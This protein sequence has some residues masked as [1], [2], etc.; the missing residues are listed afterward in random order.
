[1]SASPPPYYRH[2]YCCF[3]S[4]PGGNLS[5]IL[6][7]TGTCRISLGRVFLQEIPKHWSH[8]SCNKNIWVWFFV[9]LGIFGKLWVF[10]W[11]TRKKQVPLFPKKSL[12]LVP[13]YGKI[14]PEHGYGSQA[15][16]GTPGAAHPDPNLRPSPPPPPAWTIH[17][18][19]FI[20]ILQTFHVWR[21]DIAQDP[22][23]V[24]VLSGCAEK[25]CR[26][27]WELSRFLYLFPGF[28]YL[29]ASQNEF[30]CV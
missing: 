22:I 15:A 23:H 21:I 24:S 14:T 12:T 1:M 27:Y 18:C 9:N 8:F 16:G 5:S 29:R 10:L 2:W 28:V 30:T 17:E 4:N 6:G 26:I 11:Q 19:V 20:C 13:I 3:W 7:H 25:Y